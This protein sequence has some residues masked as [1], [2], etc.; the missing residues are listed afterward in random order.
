MVDSDRS[1]VA[2]HVRHENSMIAAAPVQAASPAPC[3]LVDGALLRVTGR[4]AVK[5]LRPLA[6]VAARRWRQAVPLP[7]T[8]ARLY[9]IAAIVFA[10]EHRR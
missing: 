6:P 5:W 1:F 3:A 4:Q 10:R 2:G 9:V 7:P 8:T